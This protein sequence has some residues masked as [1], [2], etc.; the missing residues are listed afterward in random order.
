M[1]RSITGIREELESPSEDKLL[2]DAIPGR[3]GIRGRSWSLMVV[4]VTFSVRSL[5]QH[6]HIEV[7]SGGDPARAI[8]RVTFITFFAE[9][10]SE[11]SQLRRYPN[12]G[13]DLCRVED[14][15]VRIQA[16]VGN[17]IHSTRCISGARDTVK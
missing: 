7:V 14:V 3:Q 17:G 10:L 2:R 11:V 5:E 16:I 6:L 8:H 4:A 12:D 1:R 13:L 9:Y 15:G